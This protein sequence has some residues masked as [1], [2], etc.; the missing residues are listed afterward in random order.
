MIIFLLL[1]MALLGGAI[2]YLV[3]RVMNRKSLKLRKLPLDA[4]WERL[5]WNFS[6]SGDQA[7]VIPRETKYS[8]DQ[9]N[10]LGRQHGFE[11]SHLVGSRY[12]PVGMVFNRV[13]PDPVPSRYPSRINPKEVMV[14]LPFGRWR[15][16]ST[17]G[18]SFSDSP[19]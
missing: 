6:T 15:T 8:R 3:W 10:A 13:A 17:T 1:V 16:I 19:G 4:Q 7:L 11:Y 14:K 2:G 5:V 18:A 9:I 12:E